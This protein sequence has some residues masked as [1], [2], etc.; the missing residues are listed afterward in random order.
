MQQPSLISS[1]TDIEVLLPGND[2]QWQLVR[3]KSVVNSGKYYA[4]NESGVKELIGGP[5]AGFGNISGG[6]ILNFI[7]KFSPN[8]TNII[9]S[10]LFDN[11]N[12]GYGTVT[13]NS[14]AAFDIVSTTKG[15]LFPRMTTVQRDAIL[16]DA[17]TDGLIVYNTTTEK[18]NFW[19]Q[20]LGIW[21]SIDTSTGGDVSGIGTTGQLPIWT[22]G[23]NSIIG[24]SG[25]LA[26]NVFIKGGNA[27]GANATIGLTDNFNWSFL[28]NNIV[29]GLI[30][31]SGLWSI[32][33]AVSTAGARLAI[34][35]TGTTSATYSIR[36]FNSTPT[37]IFSVR[38]DGYISA[39]VSNAMT[40][41]LGSGFNAT[42]NNTF[43]G[44]NIAP[45][46]TTGE[47]NTALGGLSLNALTSGNDNTAIGWG[48]MFRHTTGSQNTAVGAFTLFTNTTAALNTAIGY[49]ALMNSNSNSNT[50]IGY[51][52]GLNITSGQQN[53][54]IGVQALDNN[55]VGD[56]NTGIGFGSLQFTLGS[57]NASLGSFSGK[58]ETGSNYFYVNTID[59]LNIANDKNLSLLYGKFDALPVN[60]FLVLNGTLYMQDTVAPN[61]Y[62]SIVNTAGVFVFTDTGSANAPA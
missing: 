62:W 24:D 25:I 13:P 39:G 4:Y 38:D 45:T 60:Q 35:G 30:D 19:N 36:T 56:L 21:E 57:N 58:Y 15:L 52:A 17:S 44:T 5:G 41:G 48:S 43:I 10:S 20:T 22:D 59:R 34:T 6:G 55:L 53:T 14:V 61:H 23:P 29:R 8:G 54:I 3:D 33:S 27:F 26:S 18:F 51:Q 50:A 9:D 7:P 40:I 42:I 31:N 46:L 16:T 49:Q 32:G 1:A 2:N 28:T 47:H 12:I 11:G 37:E